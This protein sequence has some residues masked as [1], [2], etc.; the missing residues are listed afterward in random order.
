MHLYKYL[1]FVHFEKQNIKY[2][3]FT[4]NSHLLCLN[5]INSLRVYKREVN[6]RSSI[7]RFPIMLVLDNI[8]ILYIECI[9]TIRDLWCKCRYQFDK[10]C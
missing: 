7:V 4:E 3:F 5:V 6:E 8:V 2:L 9:V 1:F 10:H